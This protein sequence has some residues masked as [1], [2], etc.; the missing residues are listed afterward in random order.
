MVLPGGRGTAGMT[1][2]SSHI[3][4]WVVVALVAGIA[5]GAILRDALDV[6]GAKQVAGY[7]GLLTE[8]FLRLI[9]MVIAPLV[10]TTLIV[11]IANMGGTGAMGRIGFRALGWFI[12]ASLVSLS[13][14]LILVNLLQPGIGLHLELPTGDAGALRA[15]SLSLRDFITHLVPRSA[16]EAMAQN[17]ILQIVVFSGFVG[18]AC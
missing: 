11:G 7:L 13:L 15:S 2:I 14:G 4:T 18:V 8:L 1:R 3:T 10:L 6:E 16:V 17:E 12:G 5:A 9:R